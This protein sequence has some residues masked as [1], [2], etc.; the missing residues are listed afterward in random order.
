[1]NQQAVFGTVRLPEPEREEM[2]FFYLPTNPE[3]QLPYSEAKLYS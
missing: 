1:M 3:T 2:T